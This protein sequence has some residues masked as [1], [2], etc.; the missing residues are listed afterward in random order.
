MATQQRV[1]LMPPTDTNTTIPLR[2]TTQPEALYKQ[3]YQALNLK[4][5]PIGK[6]KIIIDRI[7]I[8]STNRIQLKSLTSR[9]NR[10]IFIGVIKLSIDM[11]SMVDD[12]TAPRHI[13]L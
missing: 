2:T 11:P 9:K 6:R 8:R 10:E 12:Q 4:P 3:L 1:T 13:Q 7:K 5:N